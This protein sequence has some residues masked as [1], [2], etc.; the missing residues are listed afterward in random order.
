MGYYER[1]LSLPLFPA[2]ADGDVVQVVEAL[3]KAMHL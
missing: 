2:M 3:S 1:R